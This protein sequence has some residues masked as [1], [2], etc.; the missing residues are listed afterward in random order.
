MDLLRRPG[1][2]L[3]SCKPAR[4]P[5]GLFLLPGRCVGF[6]KPIISCLDLTRLY[7]PITCISALGRP[8]FIFPSIV[9]TSPSVFQRL[10]STTR[11]TCGTLNV[12]PVGKTKKAI[13][14]GRGFCFNRPCLLNSASP[15]GGYTQLGIVKPASR[16]IV[17][18][19]EPAHN[20]PSYPERSPKGVRPLVLAVKPS[21]A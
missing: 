10:V 15:L 4:W 2:M 8:L 6:P 13:S 21:Q 12:S 17:S 7:T 5:V 11:P 20:V 18:I 19:N 9:P 3:D 14:P 1:R 16:N